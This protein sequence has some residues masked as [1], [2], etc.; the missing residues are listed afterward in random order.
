LIFSS[1]HDCEQRKLVVRLGYDEFDAFRER[2][3]DA[4]RG[5]SRLLQ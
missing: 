5:D 2:Y 4:P 1:S 3:V